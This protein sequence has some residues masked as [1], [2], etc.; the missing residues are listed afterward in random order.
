MSTRRHGS[1]E[2]IADLACAHARAVRGAHVLVGGL[3]FGFTLKAALAALAADATVLVAELLPAVVAWNRDASF[4]LAATALA[5]PRVT[6]M[7]RDVGELIRQ[8]P[9][10]FDAIILDVDNGPAALTTAGNGRLYD[11][12]GLQDARAALRPGGCVAFWSAGPSPTL[13]GRWCA[14]GSL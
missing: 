3:G 1:E 11:F 8:A 6:V 5:D 13:K 10:R 4:P 12:A 14:R 9:A 2:R 7:E